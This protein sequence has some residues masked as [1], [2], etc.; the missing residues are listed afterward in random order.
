MESD[1]TTE[2]PDPTLPFPTAD[3]NG[4]APLR[5]AYQA[6]TRTDRRDC[7]DADE[8]FRLNAD[9]LGAVAREDVVRHL[10]GCA[11][12]ARELRA[13]RQAEE[14]ARTGRDTATPPAPEAAGPT[15]APRR[16]PWTSRAGWLAA[17]AALLLI[18]VPLFRP[19]APPTD[20]ASVRGSEETGLAEAFPRG[21]VQAVPESLEW[22]IQT[23]AT[24]YV[25]KLYSAAAEL[26]WT[27]A[28]T[29]ESRALLPEDVRE[30]L[31]AAGETSFVWTVD[32][33]GAAARTEL[34]P[35]WFRL[36]PAGS[37]DP[38]AESLDG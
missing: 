14:T 34:G 7:P 37:S 21:A 2:P 23:G 27:G 35:F 20:P 4:D 31:A 29:T 8:L 1:V 13:L 6:A 38:G 22:P 25:P 9:E 15:A 17:A 16:G 30:L 28:A 32:V 11:D 33:R 24:A 19:E 36:P 5:D 3:A 10:A 12:C 18:S 26:V